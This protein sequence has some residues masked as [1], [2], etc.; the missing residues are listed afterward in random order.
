MKQFKDEVAASEVELLVIE[1]LVVFGM[2]LK[3]D[4]EAELKEA[5]SGLKS[6]TEQLRGDG[7]GKDLITKFSAMQIEL[8][9]AV[10]RNQDELKEV[11]KKVGMR[12]EW[13]ENTLK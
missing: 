6:T 2:Y 11:V 10:Q 5:V 9:A 7:F 12:K 1:H 8:Q 3:N 13:V 4:F